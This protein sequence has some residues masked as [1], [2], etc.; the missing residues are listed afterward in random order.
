SVTAQIPEKISSGTAIQSVQNLSQTFG[1]SFAVAWTGLTLQE[2]ETSGLAVILIALAFVFSYLFLVALYE[3]W[4]ISFAVIFSNIF[5]ILGALIGLTIMGLPLSI[6]AQLGLVLLV[7]LASKNAILIVEFTLAYRQRGL[8]VFK[9]SVK[10]AG[11][12]FRAVLMTALTFIIGVSPMVFASGAGAASQIA[13]G[14][15][16][17]FGMLMATLVGILFV[18]AFFALFDTWASKTTKRL[19]TPRLKRRKT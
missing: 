14:V 17:F 1:K 15:T 19:P 11:E 10:G 12:R 8:S 4:L 2:V 18:P 16:V 9:A 13:I 6:Y 7:G 5:A 3:S